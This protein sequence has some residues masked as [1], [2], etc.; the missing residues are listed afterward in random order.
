M[1]LDGTG[2][3]KFVECTFGHSW[4]NSYHGIRTIFLVHSGEFYDF[5][6][7]LEKGTVQKCVEEKYVAHLKEIEI[8]LLLSC[9]GLQFVSDH[10]KDVWTS[11]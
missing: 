2:R 10:S 6:S 1:G 3:T 7:V 9:S 5:C 8:R 11:T 4:E